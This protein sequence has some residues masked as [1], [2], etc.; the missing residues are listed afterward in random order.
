LER[1]SAGNACADTSLPYERVARVLPSRGSGRSLNRGVEQGH[2]GHHR[3]LRI[4][5]FYHDSAACLRVAGI[6][7]SDMT[8][9]GFSD[10]PLLQF[11]RIRGTFL[12][13]AP[14]ESRSVAC[15]R[16]VSDR[17]FARLSRLRAGCKSYAGHMAGAVERTAQ[18]G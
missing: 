8:R 5:A 16:H 12:G 3:I 18:R 1:L 4:S 6:A 13:V 11:D 14:R 7:A 10:N 15:S 9:V 2:M 17:C